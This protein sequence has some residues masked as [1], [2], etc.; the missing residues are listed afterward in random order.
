EREG[1]VKHGPF[2][3]WHGKDGKMRARGE[4][5]EG[6]KYGDYL[7]WH[8]NGQKKAEGEYGDDEK[9]EGDWKRWYDNGQ[10]LDEGEWKNGEPVGEWTIWHPN[11][12]KKE[13]GEFE[14]GKKVE[15]WRRWDVDGN[16]ILPPES[17]DAP[18]K[19]MLRQFEIS[20][21]YAEQ[22]DMSQPERP[23]SVSGTLKWRP[24][25]QLSRA[26]SVRGGLGLTPFKD[27]LDD[28]IFIFGDLTLTLGVQP[29]K[30]LPV[31]LAI[32][33]AVAWWASTGVVQPAI[34]TE[35]FV[36]MSLKLIAVKLTGFTI[37]GLFI[38]RG[39][40]EDPSTQLIR[41]GATLSF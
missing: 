26:F 14:A 23:Y 3:A 2:I 21:A 9:S 13:Q 41:W 34:G 38:P 33:G 22:D 20:G 1:G 25:Y 17:K 10:L 24:T 28:S 36:P 30:F 35:L 18:K 11:G 27:Q 31:G 39:D 15:P 8:P 16:E 4:F 40:D 29:L 37:N 12:N 6:K 5:R 7:E 19:L 32:G